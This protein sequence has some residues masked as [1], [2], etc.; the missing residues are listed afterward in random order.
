MTWLYIPRE[1]T[2]SPYVPASVDSTSASISPIR[3][4]EASVMW[5]GKLL[6]PHSL[7]AAWRKNVWMKLLS[8]LTLKRSTARRG[9]ESWIASLRDT[10]ANRS[11][12]PEN[13]GGKT[14]PDTSGPTSLASSR[15]F[16]FGQSS[17]RTSLGTYRWDLKQ[18]RRSFE[19]WATALRRVCLRRQKSGRATRGIGCSFW[20]TAKVVSAGDCSAERRRNTPSLEAETAMWHK[21][22]TVNRKSTRRGT[23]KPYGLQKDVEMWGTPTTRDHK[24]GTDPT[25]KVGTNGLL[26]RQTPRMMPFLCSRPDPKV[27]RRGRKSSKLTPTLPPL[28]RIMRRR[29][30]SIFV[31]WLMGLPVE[32]TGFDLSETEWSLYR[33]RMLGEFSR[34]V[35]KFEKDIG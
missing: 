21:P 1:C 13:G 16:V 5:K 19:D 3:R 30:S 29:L 10:R 11:P 14:I 32:Y 31:E 24:D 20:P 28:S 15:K 34:L 25:E 2:S 17:W 9:V 18:S 23:A 35:S 8:G 22:D 7:Y 4:L 12:R 6:P 27:S 26:G 33:R